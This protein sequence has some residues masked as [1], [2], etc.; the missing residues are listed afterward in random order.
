MSRNLNVTGLLI[1]SA[2]G[3]GC[4]TDLPEPKHEHFKMPEKA[5][6]IELPTGEFENRPYEV[7]GWVKSKADYSTMSV[8]EPLGD[9]SNCK[10][11][12]NKAAAQLVKEA[13]KAG[14]DAVIKVRSVVLLIDGKIEEHTTPECS[15][16]GQHGEILLRGVAIRFKKETH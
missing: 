12:Y 1:L 7:L 10:N 13:K 16:D 8:D 14:A 15:D 3:A 9:I 11:N 6:F 5:F 2:F 4:A